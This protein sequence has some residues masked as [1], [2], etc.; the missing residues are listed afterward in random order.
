M[1]YRVSEYQSKNGSCGLII[2]VPGA[3]IVDYNFCFRAGYRYGLDYEHKSQVAHVLEHMVAGATKQY[4]NVM[5]YEMVF[6][7][8]G[9]YNNA[10]TGPSDL[11]Y[12]A[13]CADFEWDRILGLLKQEMTQ[14][15]FDEKYLQSELGNVRSELT[16]NLSKAGRMLGP[17]LASQMGLKTKTYPE[18]LASLDNITL[19]DVQAHWRHTHTT[20]NLRFVVAGDFTDKGKLN[21]LK[22]Q[23]DNIDL[24]EGEYF[25]VLDD[26]IPHSVPALAMERKDTPAIDFR[27]TA[28]VVREY[29]D[30]EDDSM[31]ALN[32]I[33]TGTIASRIYG[34]AR[35]Q[36][37][38]YGCGSYCIADRNYAEW[39]FGGRA[40]NDKLP[41]VFD[42]IVAELKR[43]KGGDISEQELA[44]A[45]SY[46]LGRFHMGL[47]TAGQLASFLADRYFYDG[48]IK[49][50]ED[51]P[52]QIEAVA[53]EQM[54]E[55]ARE[56]FK[57]N[58]WGL[59]LWGST[60]QAMADQLRAKLA[61]L[62]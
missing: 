12:V 8:N 7:K 24:P 62:F 31:D 16:A 28:N 53:I 27:F 41:E 29:S 59:G 1:Q 23:L 5:Q 3:S 26:N 32:H 45:K 44:D 22:A 54:V 39:V 51:K 18:Y 11:R 40:S 60:D 30:A 58:I 37:L 13:A 43:V 57:S 42:L 49:K 2:S 10:M 50:F 4:P 25:D 56:Q 47:Q 34:K 15:Y 21:E 9:A 48:T 6:T 33:L 38:L 19:N 14:P 20:K 55:L 36:G 46:A 17:T 52:K 35:A 61:E